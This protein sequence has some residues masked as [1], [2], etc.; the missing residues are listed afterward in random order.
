MQT[1]NSNNIKLDKQKTDLVEFAL[2]KDT[3]EAKVMDLENTFDGTK[4]KTA[5]L[6]SW[7]DIYMPL[8]LQH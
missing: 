7:I 3:I 2:F 8:R 4:D 6:E 5:A 1:V